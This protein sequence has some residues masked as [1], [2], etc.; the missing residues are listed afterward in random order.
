MSE[1]NDTGSTPDAWREVEGAEGPCSAVW[2]V[3]DDA[4][5]AAMAVC[6]IARCLMHLAAS[7]NLVRESTWNFLAMQLD[8]HGAAVVGALTQGRALIRPLSM[9]EHAAAN[10]RK[11]AQDRTPEALEASA[12]RLEMGIEDLAKLAAERRAEA[13]AMREGMA[14]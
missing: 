1:A 11:K 8:E 7:P 14:A 5:E 9:A 3:L 10:D 2:R 13:Q 4:D 12:A 6:E